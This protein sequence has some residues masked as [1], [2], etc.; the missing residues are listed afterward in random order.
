MLAKTKP[1]GKVG[2]L[3]YYNEQ[4]VREKK[5]ECIYAGNFLKDA[6]DLTPEDKNRRF[7]DLQ[8]LN[9]RATQTAVHVVL[10]FAPEEN[11]DNEKLVDIAA[12]YM[13]RIGY[14][15][16]PYLVY[17]HFDAAAPHVHIAAIS[18]RPDGSHIYYPL[19][20]P[21]KISEPARRAVEDEFSLVKAAGH[22]RKLQQL[23]G[24]AEKIQ[25]GKLPTKEVITQTLDYIL[26]NYRYRSIAELNA[27]LRQFNLI[28]KTGRPGSRLYGF[29]GLLYQIL[30]EKGQGRGAPIK[31]SALES[32]PTLSWLETRFREFQQPDPLAIQRTRVAL[33]SILLA[34]PQDYAA[35]HDALRRNQLAAASGLDARGAITGLL[36]V[37]FASRSV[38][39]TTQ[40]G[41]DYHLPAIRQKLSFDPL[42]PSL[43]TESNQQ[44]IRQKQHKGLRI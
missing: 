18:I 41:P 36:L 16:Q 5:A 29:G 14:G 33:D 19:L 6:A 30:D 22:K 4:K 39:N 15:D 12:S 11:L 34:N 26:H 37:D 24:P 43:I 20:M 7:N 13:Q 35:F 27:I 28:A 31:A 10:Q 42:Q 21:G 1:F 40:L 25:Y 44:S 9:Q 8:S 32:K 3:L 2:K 23:T 17:R 38:I